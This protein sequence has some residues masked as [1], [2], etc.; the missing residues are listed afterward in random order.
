MKQIEVG[1]KGKFYTLNGVVTKPDKFYGIDAFKWVNNI[2]AWVKGGAQGEGGGVHL[3]R[4]KAYIEDEVLGNGCLRMRAP[5][6]LMLWGPP[7]FDLD[8]A[9]PAPYG[10]PNVANTLAL[11]NLHSGVGSAFSLTSGMKKVIRMFVN[12]AREYEI[13][14]EVPWI[15]TIKSEARGG[16]ADRLGFD[17]D[18]P[19][20]RDPRNRFENKEKGLSGVSI[21]N[22]HFLASHGIGAYLHELRT[23]GDGEGISRVDP[24]PLNLI[25]DVMNEFTAHVPTIWTPGPEGQQGQ[26]VRRMRK[27]DCPLEEVILLSQS[28]PADRYDPPLQ[29]QHGNKGYSGPCLHPPRGGAWDK[30]GD[31]MRATWPFELIDVNESQLGMTQAQRDF[32][33]PMIPKW[34]SLGSTDMAMWRRMHENFVEKEI[35]TT[36]HT[37]RGMDGYHP[38]TEETVV[39]EN[40]RAIT[41]GGGPTPIPPP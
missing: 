13:V 25:H 2:W 7:Y 30:T 23:E 28:G 34:A 1:R 19:K 29:S 21:W 41:G 5:V 39:E 38:V 33:V 6:E 10:K 11:V 4:A 15:W 22:E 18:D 32:W 36:F 9:N 8:P 24:G 27:R 12:L 37:L 3:T 16:E 14:I 40:I 17:Y 20:D 35:Y 26:V 31:V